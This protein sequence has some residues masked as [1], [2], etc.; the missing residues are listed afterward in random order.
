[1]MNAVLATLAEL[2]KVPGLMRG[3]PMSKS[4]MHTYE[5]IVEHGARQLGLYRR[6][7]AVANLRVAML[8][9]RRL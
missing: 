3:Q 7:I 6:E 8:E 4:T 5:E 9:G 1:M 2:G